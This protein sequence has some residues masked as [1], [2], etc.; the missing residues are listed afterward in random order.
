MKTGFV[1]FSQRAKFI[2]F[3]LWCIILQQLKL[4]SEFW[5]LFL[6]LNHFLSCDLGF[7]IRS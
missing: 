2:V 4:I 5:Q 7:Y 1:A 6:I 3:V